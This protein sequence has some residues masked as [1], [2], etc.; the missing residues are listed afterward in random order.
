MATEFWARKLDMGVGALL[1]FP[2][3]NIDWLRPQPGLYFMIG[4]GWDTHVGE[5]RNRC[6]HNAARYCPDQGP[7]PRQKGGADRN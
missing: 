4:R 1:S 6:G 3:G 7:P 5:F 2:S